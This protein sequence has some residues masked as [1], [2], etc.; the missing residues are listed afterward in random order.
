M[1][2]TFILIPILALVSI[3]SCFGGHK[4][5][6]MQGTYYVT[7]FTDSDGYN[8]PFITSTSYL[9][10]DINQD[11]SLTGQFSLGGYTNTGTWRD[12]LRIKYWLLDEEK[13][14]ITILY[15]GEGYT[16]VQYSVVDYGKTIEFE[17]DAY[18]RII[19]EK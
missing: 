12:I 14:N 2:N 8:A 15:D 7:Y 5:Q 16:E 18:G 10:L 19:W 13:T 9:R 3:S 17:Y 1:K 4:W 6:E 11:G